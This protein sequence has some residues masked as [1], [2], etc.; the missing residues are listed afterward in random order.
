MYLNNDTLLSIHLP[1]RRVTV[2]SD[3]KHLSHFPH[4]LTHGYDVKVS[5]D[6][7]VGH[8]YWQHELQTQKEI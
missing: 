4:P 6:Y 5:Y 7:M 2:R 8:R 1:D 3:V